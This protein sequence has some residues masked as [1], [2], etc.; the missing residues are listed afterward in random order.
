MNLPKKNR[1]QKC[2]EFAFIAVEVASEALAVFEDQL[3][4][5]PAQLGLLA[6]KMV[7]LMYLK[8]APQQPE[9]EDA[10]PPSNCSSTAHMSEAAAAETTDKS[11][12][13]GPTDE[14]QSHPRES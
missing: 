3:W 6:L 11:E 5:A 2:S 9:Q 10:E 12:P 4:S 14:Q 8:S 7:I 1:I 13:D